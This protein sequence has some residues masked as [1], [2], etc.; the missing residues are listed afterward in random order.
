LEGGWV[1]GPYTVAPLTR[2][3][4]HPFF[5]FIRT[6]CKNVRRKQVLIVA[7]KGL[8]LSSHSQLGLVFVKQYLN[9]IALQ[10]NCN[11]KFIFVIFLIFNLINEKN[12]QLWTLSIN[13]I[14][15]NVK[16]IYFMTRIQLKYF[17]HFKTI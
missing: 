10:F 3:A 2:A 8:R 11:M 17:F 12:H 5:V 15:F 7:P 6:W 9:P 4:C 14:Y 13:I 1:G 16:K